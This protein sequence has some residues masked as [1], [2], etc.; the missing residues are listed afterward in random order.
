[1]KELYV[2]PAVALRAVLINSFFLAG[3]E[4]RNYQAEGTNGYLS[5]ESDRFDWDTEEEEEW[6]LKR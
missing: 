4:I 5:R 2:K 1:M 6:L 3:S